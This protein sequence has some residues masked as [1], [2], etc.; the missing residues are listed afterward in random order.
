MRNTTL[1][2]DLTKVELLLHDKYKRFLRQDEKIT[3]TTEFKGS[4]VQVELLLANSDKAFYYPIEVR[5]HMEENKL[6]TYKEGFDVLIDFM[7]YYLGEFF[8]EE[9]ELYLPI[10]YAEM[11]FH[12][13][14]IDT[15]GQIFNRKLEE[16]ADKLLSGELK[17]EDID[18]PNKLRY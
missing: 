3:V 17:P 16:L 7:D 11:S 2:G 4:Y 5:I 10:E 6:T 14:K 8:S 12:K 13:Y 1:A 18:V 15:R 9:R